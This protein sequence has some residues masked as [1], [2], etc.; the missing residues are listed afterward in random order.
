MARIVTAVLIV[1]ALAACEPRGRVVIAPDAAKTGAIETVFIATTRGADPGTG[2]AFGTARSAEARFLRLD[3]AI[4]PNR[5]PGE[6]AW[7]HPRR[8]PDP[9]T[10]FLAAR[11]ELY[12]GAPEFRAD[13]AAA[14]ARN[15][16]RGREAVVFIHGFNNNFAEGAYR[17]A[18]LGHD[19]DLKGVL[20]HYSWPSRAQPLRYAYDRD[21]A[22]FA[23]DGLETLLREVEAAG[24][25]RILIMAHSMGSA[26][27]MEALRQIAI[28]DD[29]RLLGKV[30]GVVL[31]SPDIDVDVFRAQ[32]ARI[33]DLPQPFAIFTSKR[34][35]ALALSARLTGQRDRLGNV[36]DVED[37][38]DLEVTLL[39]TTAF[40]AGSGHFNPG[41]SPA[42][43]AILGK[44]ADVDAAFAGD[45]TGRAGLLPGAVLTVQ[46][47][48]QIVLS[49]VTA[50]S[51][52][53]P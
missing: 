30:S 42:L 16:R 29:R 41:E 37:V 48:T 31:V 28:R 13:L 7:P 5:A 18:Q 24:A 43:L 20:V 34:D 46:N 32:A 33:G 8:A 12:A 45:R 19:L 27:T 2:E 21:S 3:V 47:A 44:L 40:S 26:L 36:T 51:Q 23:R 14:L 4:P 35:R 6:I 1:L 38:A 22:L 9:A 17:L 15:P 53:Q 11:Q 39:D 49:P 52:I 50:I 25:D 10:E